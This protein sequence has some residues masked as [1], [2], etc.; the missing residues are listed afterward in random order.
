MVESLCEKY[1]EEL[2]CNVSSSGRS[3]R[4][5]GGSGR[6]DDEENDKGERE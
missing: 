1:G 6:D 3:S 5:S 2:V 4:S